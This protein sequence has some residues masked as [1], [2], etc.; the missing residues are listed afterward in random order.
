MF[1]WLNWVEL[2]RLV[3]VMEMGQPGAIR[4]G[5]V[6][7]AL[8]DSWKFIGQRRSVFRPMISEYI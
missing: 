8:R 2:S 5:G 7:G 6:D 3:S 1:L 4:A